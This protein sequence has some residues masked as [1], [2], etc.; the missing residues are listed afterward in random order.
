MVLSGL[1][2][3][4]VLAAQAIRQRQ[5]DACFLV[6]LTFA[7]CL[8]WAFSGSTLVLGALAADT[9]LVCTRLWQRDRKLLAI[10]QPAL[11]LALELITIWI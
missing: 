8:A 6:L 7:L 3:F 2:A 10:L 9:A 4:A 11:I 5:T 1:A